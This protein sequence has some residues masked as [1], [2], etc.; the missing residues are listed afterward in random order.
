VES[1]VESP[2]DALLLEQ[3]AVAAAVQ[4]QAVQGQAV[5]RVQAA[6]KKQPAVQVAVQVAVA[7]QAGQ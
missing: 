7:G 4:G 2:V 3:P 5:V 6:G 1:P